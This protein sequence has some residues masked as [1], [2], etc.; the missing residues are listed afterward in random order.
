MWRQHPTSSYSTIKKEPKTCEWCGKEMNKL[1]PAFCP[2][3]SNR[4]EQDNIDY[5]EIDRKEAEEYREKRAKRIKERSRKI[6]ITVISIA[7]IAILSL[8]IFIIVYFKIKSIIGIIFIL[9]FTVCFFRSLAIQTID[10][11]ERR[12]NIRD[13]K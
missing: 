8:S 9:G 11:I 6:T 7:L 12:N 3:C 1:D 13:L 2:N 10:G 5:D 4:I